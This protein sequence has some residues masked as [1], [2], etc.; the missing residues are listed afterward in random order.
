MHILTRNILLCGLFAAL[1]ATCDANS[2]V[3]FGAASFSGFGIAGAGTSISGNTLTAMMP[4]FSSGTTLTTST[5]FT[6]PVTL[7][8]QI[9]GFSYDFSSFSGP[10][11]GTVTLKAGT[12]QTT[13][14]FTAPSG[15]FLVPDA[16][17]SFALEADIQV[18]GTQTAS[19][20]LPNFGL[21]A[22][23][24]PEPVTAGFVALGLVAAGLWARRKL[25]RY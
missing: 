23:P 20:T 14:A 8:G 15:F 25:Q 13:F 24:T 3:S 17:P 16:P 6:D 18:T 2:I 11:T 22:E 1:A 12:W 19:T 10:G 21:T 4:S 5:M 9:S 7:G